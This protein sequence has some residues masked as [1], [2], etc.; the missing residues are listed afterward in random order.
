MFR[1]EYFDYDP[2]T[3]IREQYEDLGDGRVAIHSYQDVQPFLDLAASMRNEGLADAAWKEHG[4]STYAIVPPILQNMLRQRGIDF[5]NPN[6]TPALVDAINKD[7]PH[8]K[9]TYMKHAL[10]GNDF[11]K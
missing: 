1:G 9:T 7:F 3:G 4:A 6:H 2:L 8:F 10:R 5:M 11:G